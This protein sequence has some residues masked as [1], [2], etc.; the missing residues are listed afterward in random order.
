[1][2][3]IY[4]ADDLFIKTNK[5]LLRLD[6]AEMMEILLQK[7]ILIIL[8]VLYSTFGQPSDGQESK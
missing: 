4:Y 1:M 8:L 7:L 6:N 5:Q 3:K 2:F